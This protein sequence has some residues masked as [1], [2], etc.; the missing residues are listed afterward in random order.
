MM[1]GGAEVQASATGPGCPSGQEAVLLLPGLGRTPRCFRRLCR[2]LEAC[3]YRARGWP[4]RSLRGG[5]EQHGLRLHAELGELEAGCPPRSIHLVTH[6]MGGIVVRSALGRGVP[7]C[8]GRVVM[9]APPHRGS[10]IARFLAPTL[11]RIIRP[12]AE[13]SDSPQSTVNRLAPLHG[14]EV[15]IIAAACDPQVRVRDTHLDGEAEHLVVPGMHTFIM[16]RRDV[17]EQ[18]AAFLRDGRFGRPV[19][20]PQWEQWRSWPSA[21]L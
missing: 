10:R 2:H 13:L 5:I 14:V 1:S 11:G 16:N 8:V 15:G 12:L 19:S 18:V 7:A 4:Y 6:S 20:S 3:G 21:V 9:L 17:C